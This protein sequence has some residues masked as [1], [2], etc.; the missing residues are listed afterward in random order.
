MELA[1][2]PACRVLF[3]CQ[4]IVQMSQMQWLRKLRLLM[5]LLLLLLH[6]RPPQYFIQPQTVQL[7]L[8]QLHQQ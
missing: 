8:V 5:A 1:Q 6:H 2:A 7:L 3:A 4:K